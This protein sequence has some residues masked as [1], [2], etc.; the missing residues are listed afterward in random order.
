MERT[1]DRVAR[2]ASEHRNG[3]DFRL[4]HVVEP[5]HGFEG[6]SELLGLGGRRAGQPVGVDPDGAK[7]VVAGGS[8]KGAGGGFLPEDAAGRDRAVELRNVLRHGIGKGYRD[9][10]KGQIEGC[11][12]SVCVALAFLVH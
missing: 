10:G 2:L 5:H 8:R 1:V 11:R 3:G 9:G 6:G 4:A 12:Q 7:G